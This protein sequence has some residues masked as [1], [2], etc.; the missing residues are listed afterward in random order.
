MVAESS[1]ITAPILTG[2]N[3]LW[4]VRWAISRATSSI[5]EPKW[6]PAGTNIWKCCIPPMKTRQRIENRSVLDVLKRKGDTLKA[7][8]NIFHW[9]YFR[10][11][12]DRDAFW[13]AIQPLEYRMKSQP[14]KHGDALPFGICI[15]RF[16]SVKQDDVD[17]AVIELFRRAKE[18]QGDYDGWE[19]E[20]I[21]S[22]KAQYACGDTE[23]ARSGRFVDDSQ[24]GWV[25]TPVW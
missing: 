20:V 13:S 17:E 10:T 18:F 3:L 14:E 1:T 15:V 2:S 22:E 16:Q 5:A 12:N 24:P 6:T 11:K 8:R 19:T 25:A 9:I 21:L 23:S 4:Q 7:P